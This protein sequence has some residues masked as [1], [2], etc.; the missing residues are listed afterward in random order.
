MAIAYDT[1]SASSTTEGTPVSWSH[2]C[3]GTNRYLIV[4]LYSADGGALSDWTVTYNGVSMSYINSREVGGTVAL[5]GLANP[6]SGTNT[7]SATAGTGS[8]VGRA[9]SYTGVLQSGQPEANAAAT[10][11]TL[12]VS[13]ST[14]YA[15][16]VAVWGG[17]GSFT[18]GSGTV[19]R[20]QGTSNLGGQFALG[21]SDG[22]KSPAGSYSLI[23]TS[24]SEYGVVVVLSNLT[25]ASTL[26]M[27]QGSFSITGF[28]LGMFVA[29]VLALAQGAFSFTGQAVTLLLTQRWV[30][31]NKSSSAMSNTS[32]N[33][34]SWSNDSKNNS[35]MTNQNKN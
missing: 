4:A 7:I 6:D 5:Y 18:A 9:V 8:A 24:G 13:S 34:S 16:L 28:T 25:T 11:S 35:T 30:N 22:A 33:S 23:A 21:D 19:I 31:N 12:T 32:K 2:T 3:T 15:W 10:S 17:T 1:S 14:D 29:R 26:A 27:A 20:S